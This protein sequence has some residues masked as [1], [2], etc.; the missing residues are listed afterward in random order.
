MIKLDDYIRISEWAKLNGISRQCAYAKVRKGLIA[1]TISING[2]IFINKN[3]KN[4]K[5]KPYSKR[6]KAGK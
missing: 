3:F 1:D 2:M 4:E 5:F 6:K